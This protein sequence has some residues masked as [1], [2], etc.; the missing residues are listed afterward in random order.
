MRADRRYGIP[1]QEYFAMRRVRIDG[2]ST[3]PSFPP[4]SSSPSSIPST[5]P[6]ECL[7]VKFIF[8][9]VEQCNQ[10]WHSPCG[11]MPRK[12]NENVL[13]P[14]PLPTPT[15]TPTRATADANRASTK[16]VARWNP[17]TVC[18]LAAPR[19]RQGKSYFDFT[20]G[21]ICVHKSTRD[22]SSNADRGVL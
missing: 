1:P 20:S 11:I 15:P 8:F 5:Y 10:P 3:A 7:A 6:R 18:V 12:L 9:L 16:F 21:A 4:S 2:L 17:H 22:A 14:L 13:A 19:E